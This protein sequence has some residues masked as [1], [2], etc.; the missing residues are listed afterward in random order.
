MYGPGVMR[1]N[2]WN[3]ARWA[4]RKM[5]LGIP[6]GSSVLDVGS[7]GNPNPRSTVLVEKAADSTHRIGESLVRDDR[8]LVFADGNF[9][10]FQDKVF[11]FVILSHVLEHVSDPVP[12]LS[13]IER[14][15]RAGYIETP[16]A[17]Q[18]RLAPYDI[19]CLEVR[20]DGDQL[21][22]SKKSARVVEPFLASMEFLSSAPQ[23]RKFLLSHPELFHV[24]YWW[25]DRINYS[26]DNPDQDMSWFTE[27]WHGE[28]GVA[29]GATSGHGLRTLARRLA[30]WS[31]RHGL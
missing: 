15:G 19:H 23:M 18:E 10:P 1:P 5:R 27:A 6:P 24:R 7:G 13:E 20:L 11:D 3:R 29:V 28:G 25:K 17:V 9:L 2:P 12:F 8:P 22:I 30:R 16:N 21:R 31:V 14:V 26:I 4:A